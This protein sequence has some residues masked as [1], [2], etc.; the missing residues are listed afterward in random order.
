[1]SESERPRERPRGVHGAHVSPQAPTRSAHGRHGIHKTA[2]RAP[3]LHPPNR[4]RRPRERPRAPSYR[5]EGAP[6]AT[7]HPANR[8][9]ERT[10]HGT[11][12]WLDRTP[13]R[14][15]SP[16]PQLHPA[17]HRH[18]RLP[19]H[20]PRN[21][22]PR[23]ARLNRIRPQTRGTA[24]R[25]RPTAPWH[26]RRLPR[27]RPRRPRGGGG[28]TT[29]LFD[30]PGMSGAPTPSAHAS[31]TPVGAPVGARAPHPDEI[32]KFEMSQAWEANRDQWG[33]PKVMLP[34]G[35]REVGYRRA[36]SYGA[37]LENDKMLVDWKLR[38]VARG[39]ARRKPLQLAITRAEVG[40]D[41]PDPGMQRKA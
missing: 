22:R 17:A 1:M 39:V 25:T 18:P 35:S 20:H 40:L 29:D 23:R 38:Q 8:G 14:P 33:R 28:M 41:V 32:R 36:S 10:T 31:H 27:H 6:W 9:R 11:P 37:P 2:R 4:P 21:R 34:D 30:P 19:A 7:R 26:A 12:P 13:H 3:T 5:E 15:A 16:N 24:R